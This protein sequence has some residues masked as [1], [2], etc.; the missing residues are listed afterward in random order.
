MFLLAKQR[1]WRGH[2]QPPFLKHWLLASLPCTWLERLD[3][4]MEGLATILSGVFCIQ[5]SSSAEC[6]ETP[7]W[8]IPFEN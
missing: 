2:G 1:A 5:L 8:W 3:L 6:S 7:G 4:S